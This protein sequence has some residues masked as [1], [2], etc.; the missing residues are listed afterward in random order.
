[1]CLEHVTSQLV[2]CE[3]MYR[4]RKQLG[5]THIFLH[6]KWKVL[7]LLTCGTGN[8]VK[9]NPASTVISHTHGDPE[10]I[11]GTH[12]FVLE[13]GMLRE[14]SVQVTLDFIPHR[15]CHLEVQ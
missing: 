11:W 1:M 6:V 3:H 9:E 14:R 13:R 12:L 4:Y 10:Q 7:S 8:V 15:V 5:C 2:C